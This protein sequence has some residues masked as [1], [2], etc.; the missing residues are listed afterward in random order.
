MVHDLLEILGVERVEDVEEV[1]SGGISLIGVF[2]L[3]KENEL[4]VLLEILPQ[5][6][7]GQ[8]LEVGDMDVVDLLLF[9]ELLLVVEDLLQEVL[10]AL[11]L[12]RDIILNYRDVRE[13]NNR[14]YVVCPC[15]NKSRPWKRACPGTPRA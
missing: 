7:D 6:L 14:T 8:L 3:E 1:L 13:K 15:T 5:V 11:V 12:G 4:G 10:V 2:V 9:E